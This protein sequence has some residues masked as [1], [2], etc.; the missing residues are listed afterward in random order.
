MPLWSF[1]VLDGILE[2]ERSS[3]DPESA[4]MVTLD[5]QASRP[6]EDF[7]SLQR[8]HFRSPCYSNTQRLGHA[9]FP[10]REGGR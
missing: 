4:G 8:R 5:L 2:A 10:A 1:H 7:Y 6:S 9:L 3:P